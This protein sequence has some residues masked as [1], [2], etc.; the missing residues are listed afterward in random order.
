MSDFLLNNSDS[1]ADSDEEVIILAS[2]FEI[3]LHCCTKTRTLLFFCSCK[4]LMRKVYWNRAWMK[5]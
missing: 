3:I 4:K 1:E 5:K 2:S